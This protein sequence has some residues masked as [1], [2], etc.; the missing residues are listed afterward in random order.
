MFQRLIYKILNLKLFGCVKMKGKY[1][2]SDK[3]IKFVLDYYLKRNKG[4]SEKEIAKG[5]R[6]ILHRLIGQ[7][8]ARKGHRSF[9]EREYKSLFE[10][11]FLITGSV[12][13]IVDVGCGLNPLFFKKFKYYAYDIDLDVLEKVR[14]HF[15]KNK[16]KGGVYEKNFFVDFS[17]PKADVAFLF[18]ILRLIDFKGHKNAEKLLKSLRVK[19]IV[20]S[21]STRTLAGRKMNY[22]RVG[23]FER[24][25]K[26]L[27]L[28]YE[29]F[30]WKDETFYLIKKG[31]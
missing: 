17:Y 28:K 16:I 20:A 13:S 22:P 7:Y 3:F 21:F 14:E 30:Y 25:L 1:N 15:V 24:L 5:V 19:W 8:K 27:G 26:R 31:L 12:K 2:V 23:W 11:V 29:K 18:K 9:R 10:K 4:K 6:K